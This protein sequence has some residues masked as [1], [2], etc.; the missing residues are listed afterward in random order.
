MYVKLMNNL[1][2]LKLQKMCS[3]VPTYLNTAVEEEIPIID[4][5]VHL[6]DKEIA[7]KNEMASKIQIVE[8]DFLL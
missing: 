6:T 2:T 8:P 3:Y 4:A 5:L 7:Y 1:E